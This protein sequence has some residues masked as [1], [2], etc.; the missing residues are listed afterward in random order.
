VTAQRITATV[1]DSSQ[2]WMSR[3]GVLCMAW[4]L[5]CNPICVSCAS[6]LIEMLK[7]ALWRQMPELI[8][9]FGGSVS[10]S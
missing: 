3:Q 10:F 6:L 4:A 7:T 9:A 1:C 5:Q 2:Q 8:V